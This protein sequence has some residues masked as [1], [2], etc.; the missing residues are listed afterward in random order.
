[1]TRLISCLAACLI[2]LLIMAPIYLY[3]RDVKIPATVP[4]LT[5][6]ERA[7]CE[8]DRRRNRIGNYTIVKAADG[9]Y[10]D[11]GKCAEKR[12]GEL[13]GKRKCR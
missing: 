7:V 8:R 12:A 13:C 9:P 10:F 6:E 5:A 2:L 3:H 4:K 1:M 11:F